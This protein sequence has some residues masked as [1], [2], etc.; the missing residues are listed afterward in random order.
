MRFRRAAAWVLAGAAVS[1]IAAGARFGR[2]GWVHYGAFKAAAE[3]HRAVFAVDPSRAGE[4]TAVWEQVLPSACDAA[5][6]CEVPAD[7]LAGLTARLTLVD[8]GTVVRDVPIDAAAA[9]ETA[10]VT[11]LAF[12]PPDFPA[13]RY[14][15]TLTVLTPA[16]AAGPA[17]VT[18]DYLI[19]GLEVLPAYACFAAAAGCGLAAVLCGA[20][21]V[22]LRRTGGP[23]RG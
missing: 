2:A 20:V 17:T 5:V 9:H 1:L 13:G 12:I 10:G 19:C 15:A 18:A 3:G 23:R 16:A 21:A 22:G 11:T 7:D 4:A 6:W 8:A 14:A